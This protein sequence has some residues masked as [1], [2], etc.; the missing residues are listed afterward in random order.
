VWEAGVVEGRGVVMVVR[1]DDSQTQLVSELHCRCYGHEP[2]CDGRGRLVLAR[3]G[4]QPSDKVSETSV[5][6]VG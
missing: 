5:P 2:G 1:L 4:I 6:E 3:V